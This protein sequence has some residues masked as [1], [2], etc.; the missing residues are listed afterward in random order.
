MTTIATDVG[1]ESSVRAM[2]D[3][4]AAAYGRVDVIVHSATVMAY[5]DVETLPSEVFEKV[6]DTA[7]HGTAHIARAAFALFRRQGGGTVIVVNSLLGTI[8]APHMG[9]Y[10]TAKWGQLGLTRVLQIE[11]RRI[12]GVHVC[13]V[14]PGSIN[15]PIY[16]Q[17]A[18]HTGQAARPPW[19]VDQ[20]EKVAKAIVSLADRPRRRV[21]VGTLNPFT[22]FGFRFLPMVYDRIVTTLMDRAA[23]TRQPLEPTSGN[24][25]E[26]NE[27][28]EAEFGH[29]PVGGW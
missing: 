29:W 20:P 26:P 21:S 6:V 4:A 13:V 23:L 10:A 22:V 14:V 11:A 28:A 25:F 1:V 18:N 7:I 15:T 9:A 3:Q 8:V 24:V 12:P 27:A 5:G 17:A 16:Y 19:P 2:L